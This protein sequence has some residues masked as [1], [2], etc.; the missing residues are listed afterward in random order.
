[1][2]VLLLQFHNK[3]VWLISP[4]LKE[5]R[6]PIASLGD[7]RSLVGGQRDEILFTDLLSRIAQENNLFVVTKAPEELIPFAQIKQLEEK[8]DLKIDFEKEKEEG[9][10]GYTIVDHVIDELN[11][12]IDSLANTT[13][14]HSD[15]IWIGRKLQ[16]QGAKLYYRDKLHT[17]LLWTPIGALIG[18]AN[19][20]NAGLSLNDEVMLKIT[21]TEELSNLQNTAEQI[22][23]R[24]IPA[25]KYNLKQNLEKSGHTINDYKNFLTRPEIMDY[26]N[27]KYLLEEI[28]PF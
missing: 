12:D 1:M 10:A 18:S 19:F 20:T 9:L 28:L 6:L 5:F 27:I 23:K 2:L 25:Q 3:N 13:I 17:N 14:L 22:V 21:T 4:W 15:T 7:F 26:P 24:S 8:L 11:R 16:A